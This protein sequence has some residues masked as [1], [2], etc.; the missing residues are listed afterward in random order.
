MATFG[1]YLNSQLPPEMQPQPSGAQRVAGLLNSFYS[2]LLGTPSTYGGLLSPDA[3]KD[4]QRQQRIALGAQL[5]Q[6]SGPSRTPT[7]FGQ[8]LGSAVQAGNQAGYVAQNQ[9]VDTALRQQELQNKEAALVLR[10]GAADPAAIAEWKYYAGL[11][12]EDQRR[13]LELKRSQNPYVLGDVAG[14]KVKFNKQTGQFE[15]VTTASQEASGAAT[16]AGARAGAE[17]TAEQQAGAQFDLPR[18]EQNVAQAKKDIEDLKNDPSLKYITG[19]ASLAPTIPGTGQARAISKYEQ[20]KGQTFLQ[21]YQQ[22]RGSGQISDT[23]GRK[24][25][26]AVGRLNRAQNT[27]DF[28]AALSELEDVLD[29]GLAKARKQANSNASS[30]TS[31]PLGIR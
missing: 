13:F 6:A 8:V 18:V 30:N 4:I 2:G 7:N 10:P 9:A 16:V 22:L 27:T 3:I 19:A 26:A 24:A 31:D 1:D 23:E 11:S 14:G 12:P 28:V 25:E 21:A 20:I 5:L 15:R 17:K 29:S